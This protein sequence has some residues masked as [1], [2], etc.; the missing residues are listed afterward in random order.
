MFNELSADSLSIK[1]SGTQLQ[2]EET[3]D[4]ENHQKV[5][6]GV[7]NFLG[8]TH[9]HDV[10][11]MTIKKEYT[12]G[13]LTHSAEVN[14]PQFDVSDHFSSSCCSCLLSRFR[15]MATREMR[16]IENMV[17]RPFSTG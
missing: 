12:E 11:E 8:T 7:E 4:G 6:S 13:W 9:A 5:L 17:A 1:T 16:S 3:Q 14:R 15:E 10:D 2:V